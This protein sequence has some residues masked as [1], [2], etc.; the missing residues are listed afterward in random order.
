MYQW[1]CSFVALLSPL[2][3]LDIWFNLCLSLFYLPVT[4]SH[5]HT[6]TL[7]TISK[8]HFNTLTL[9]RT[10]TQALTLSFHL[11]FQLFKF[12][13]IEQTDALEQVCVCDRFWVCVCVIGFECVC[14]IGFECVRVC[15]CVKLGF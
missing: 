9:S 8:S 11:S 1:V 2:L 4:F 6:L 15:V 7:S 13:S 14:V 3:I 5:K 10:R 12:I